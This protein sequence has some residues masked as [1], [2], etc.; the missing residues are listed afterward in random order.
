M[1]SFLLPT[2]ILVF[3][4]FIAK[5]LDSTLG[6][7]YG[8]LLA[9]SLLLLGFPVERVVPALLLSEFVSAALT[10]VSHRAM[11]TISSHPLSEDFRISFVLSTLGVIGAGVGVF[12]ALST[13]SAF[14]TFYVLATVIFTG[15][16]VTAGFRWKFSWGR[17]TIMGFIA[18]LNKALSGGGYGPLVAGGQMIS[19][20]DG[21]QALGTTSTAE[22]FTTGA[23]WFLYLLVGRIALAWDVL[24]T[25]EIPLLIG[26]VASA[27]IAAYIVNRVNSHKLIPFVGGAAVSLGIVAMANLIF[28]GIVAIG[29]ALISLIVL[30]FGA[31]WLQY[32]RQEL[33]RAGEWPS[34]CQ[35]Y[36]E[37]PCEDEED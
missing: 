19:G 13:A 32:E 35:I 9:P 21:K 30:V 1:D 36:D 22:A 24:S 10:A 18:S 5:I 7:G 4:G 8:T 6:L 34:P 14:I 29:A 23:S 20:R 31:S 15:T 28:G 33:Q 25:F 12:V 27:P 37:P 11:G 2:V 16:L 26:A 3:V 17:I